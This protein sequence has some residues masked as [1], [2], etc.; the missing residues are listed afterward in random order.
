VR[1][2]GCPGDPGNHADLLWASRGGGGGNFGI[3]T[4]FTFKFRPISTVTIYDATWGSADWHHVSELF[5]VWQSLAPSADN[6]LGSIFSPNSKKNGSI[7]SNGIFIGS[8]ETQLR[9]LLQPLLGIG[10]PKVTIQT[11]SYLDA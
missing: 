1:Q 9:Q 2:A 11:M 3:A 7:A 4:S 6:R 10:T 5:S 8:Q